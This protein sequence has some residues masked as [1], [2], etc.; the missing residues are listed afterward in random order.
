MTGVLSVHVCLCTI[1]VVS[2]VWVHCVSGVAGADEAGA[3]QVRAVVLAQLLIT[4]TIHTKVW[5][6]TTQTTFFLN[7]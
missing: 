7:T 2:A 3:V 6:K 5:S 4:V 1:A